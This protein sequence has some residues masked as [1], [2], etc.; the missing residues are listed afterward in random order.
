MIQSPAKNGYPCANP[1]KGCLNGGEDSASNE[2]YGY[3]ES[4]L[5]SQSR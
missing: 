1:I 2:A 3:V 5:F 4:G